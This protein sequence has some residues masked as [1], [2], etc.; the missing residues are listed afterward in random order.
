MDSTGFR[1]EDFLF[2]QRIKGKKLL[3]KQIMKF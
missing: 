2:P 1:E 3:I